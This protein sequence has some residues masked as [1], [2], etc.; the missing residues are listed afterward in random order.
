[1][2]SVNSYQSTVISGQLSESRRPKTK[3]RESTLPLKDLRDVF[4]SV[5][6][7]VLREWLKNNRGNLRGLELKHIEAIEKLIFSRK[8]GKVV[9]LPKGESV[10]KNDGKLHFQNIKVEKS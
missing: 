6:R 5:L 7:I 1:R 2:L 3:V 10:L 9:E 4:P 8:S